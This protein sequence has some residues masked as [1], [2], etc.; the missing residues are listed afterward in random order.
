MTPQLANAETIPIRPS[1]TLSPARILE[2]SAER[3]EVVFR[4]REDV[5]RSLWYQRLKAVRR[6]DR[7]FATSARNAEIRT[8]E[9]ERAEA[10]LAQCPQEDQLAL[11]AGTY[12]DVIR[13]EA[14][15]DIIRQLLGLFLD[16]FPNARPPSASTFFETL[17]HDIRDVGFT[18]AVVAETCRDLRRR[19][20]FVP[21]V[22]EF[23]EACRQ[24]QQGLCATAAALETIISLRRAAELSLPSRA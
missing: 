14:N 24:T 13:A 23:L 12:R 3:Y 2:M 8:R 5:E 15:P 22:A 11:R 4:D 16:A 7:Q 19:S 20:K 21:T 10:I 1:V 9:V 18:E 17:A 6:E